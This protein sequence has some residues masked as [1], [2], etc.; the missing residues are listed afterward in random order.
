MGFDYRRR[1]NIVLVH[2]EIPGNTGAIGR[3]CVGLEAS[4]T[5]VEPLGFS[6]ED[7]YLKRAGLDYWP[8]LSLQVLPDWDAFLGS[9]P[10]ASRIYLFTK[11]AEQVYSHI[12]FRAGDFLVFGCETKGLPSELTRAHAQA[13]LK[14]P[15]LGPIRSHNLAMAVAI[16]AYEA[17][18]QIEGGF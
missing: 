12:G 9:I 4:L 7:R 8:N 13:C 11:R 15:L 10:E 18:R 17:A 14:I 5:L 6:L 2:P 1:L 16:A 3:L